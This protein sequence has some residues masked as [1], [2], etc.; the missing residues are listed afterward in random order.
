M[1]TKNA[2]SLVYDEATKKILVLHEYGCLDITR[3]FRDYNVNYYGNGIGCQIE[4]T[5][6]AT[7]NPDQE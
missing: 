1:A 2:L 3:F 5:V 6:L 4:G 7:I